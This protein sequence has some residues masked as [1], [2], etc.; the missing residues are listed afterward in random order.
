MQAVEGRVREAL[1][2][3]NCKVAAAGNT[4]EAGLAH[5][6]AG[7][8]NQVELMGCKADWGM[9]V[10]EAARHTEPGTVDHTAEELVVCTADR[11]G[12]EVRCMDKIQGHRLVDRASLVDG[13]VQNLPGVARHNSKQAQAVQVGCY[14]VDCEDHHWLVGSGWVVEQDL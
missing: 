11:T 9:V 2:G 5:R 3:D 8:G 4:L 10:Q 12:S 7:P 6:K 14:L 1:A 13:T